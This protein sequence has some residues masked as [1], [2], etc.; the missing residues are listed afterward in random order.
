MEPLSNDW[1]AAELDA[2]EL[3]RATAALDEL[4]LI[5]ERRHDGTLGVV[6]GVFVPTEG[7]TLIEAIF[8]LVGVEKRR[9]K[10]AD[11]QA[12]KFK[13]GKKALGLEGGPDDQEEAQ[14][15]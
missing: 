9:R 5:I 2:A 8:D 15:E 1:L 10:Q 11:Q 7:R 14:D 4:D 6:H 12:H 13:Q 3:A